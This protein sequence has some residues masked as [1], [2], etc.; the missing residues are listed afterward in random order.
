MQAL[1]KV[2]S[3]GDSLVGLDLE[4]NQAIGVVDSGQQITVLRFVAASGAGI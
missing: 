2:G 1:Q 4:I 3:G